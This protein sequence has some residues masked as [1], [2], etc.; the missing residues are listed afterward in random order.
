MY[1]GLELLLKRVVNKG[2]S[3]DVGVFILEFFSLFLNP[4]NTGKTL[5]KYTGLL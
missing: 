2:D 4:K 5:E 3:P 1:L